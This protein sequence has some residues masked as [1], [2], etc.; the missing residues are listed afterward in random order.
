[1]SQERRNLEGIAL[2][3]TA[4]AAFIVN[5]TILKFVM[6]D[7]PPFETLFLRG[8]ATVILGVPLLAVTGQI[9]ALPRVFDPAVL[10]R[11]AFELLA[12]LGYIIGLAYA[13]IADVTALSQLAPMLLT[14]AAVWFFGTR[15]GRGEIALICLAFFGALMVA[16]P[17]GSGFSAF[18]LFGLW[19]A[20]CC[21]GRDLIGRQVKA[22]VPGL[23]VPIGAGLIVLVGA[24]VAT[25]IF[26]KFVVPDGRVV[27]LLFASALFL[28]IGHLFIFLAYRKGAVGAV[29]PF[30]YTG[31]IWALIAGF[32]AFQTLPN[33]L[34]LAGIAVILASGVAV[35]VMDGRRTRMTGTA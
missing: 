1:M 25:L 9:K 12:V 18:A 32:V 16:Q 28:T 11:N 3:T 2:M 15:I 34:A 31:T 24:A 22:D 33:A 29:A 30:F 20:V 7:I 23:V 5:D 19:N 14:L 26:E 8:I 17:G 6:A 10:G 4:T 27:A 35:V 21:A 13:P